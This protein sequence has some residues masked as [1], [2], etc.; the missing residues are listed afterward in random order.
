MS[1]NVNEPTPVPQ[2]TKAELFAENPDR[3]QDLEEVI[4]QV[5][6]HPENGMLGIL[7][8]FGVNEES[9]KEVYEEALQVQ[10]YVTRKISQFLSLLEAETAKK[11]QAT[12]I[13]K[14]N[15]RMP[16]M[17]GAFGKKK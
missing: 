13:V 10:S 17:G 11:K 3:F 16:F 1:V 4:I 5:S 6:R 2:K 15:G 8:R 9:T 12:E 7:M 14:P